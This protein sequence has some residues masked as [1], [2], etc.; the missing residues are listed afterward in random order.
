ME[1]LDLIFIWQQNLF[2]HF[3]SIHMFEE[4][5]LVLVS[6]GCYSRWG[7]YIIY[8]VGTILSSYIPINS[9]FQA[10][11]ASKNFRERIV[12]LC[13]QIKKSVCWTSLVIQWLS[14]PSN[15]EDMG[16]LVQEDSTCHGAAKPVHHNY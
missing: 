11:L 10:H 6:T 9:E 14:P 13:I 3:I 5:T 12:H 4:E 15:A 2:I 7:C 1:K 8:S 16:S